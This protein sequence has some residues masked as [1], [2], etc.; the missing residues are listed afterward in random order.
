MIYLWLQQRKFLEINAL[1]RLKMLFQR[2]YSSKS[3]GGACPRIHL[4]APP[5]SINLTLLRH[6]SVSNE[7]TE[8]TWE[9]EP[10]PAIQSCVTGQRYLFW[11]LS[12]DH[13][14][15][16]FSEIS[17]YSLIL[18]QSF[19][20]NGIKNMARS[21]GRFISGISILH[22]TSLCTVVFWHLQKETS[23]RF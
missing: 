13:I 14:K 5:P 7:H 17:F 1:R 20:W 4:A 21:M 6:C 8:F 23:A 15:F 2:P 10:E 16:C 3:S 12:I 11:Q 19:R 22:V 18:F 9:N